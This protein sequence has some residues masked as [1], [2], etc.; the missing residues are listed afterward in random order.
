[1]SILESILSGKG[2]KTV[3]IS[4][5]TTIKLEYVLF[6]SVL[7]VDAT[8]GNVIITLP[9]F[10]YLWVG[11]NSIKIKRIDDSFNDVTIN[12]LTNGEDNNLLIHP[13]A[14]VE[15]YASKDLVWRSES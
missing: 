15:F 8:A 14:F 4:G 12:D 5:S 13:L 11:R 6:N 2:S 7:E 3:A 9:I 10:D 1:M